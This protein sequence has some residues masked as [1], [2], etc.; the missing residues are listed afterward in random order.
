MVL[1]SRR[2]FRVVSE[3]WFLIRREKGF[4]RIGDIDGFYP[5]DGFTGLSPKFGFSLKTKRVIPRYGDTDGFYP[6]DGFTGLSP[7]FG[8]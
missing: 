5:V 3:V 4:P 1:P 8:F 7:K 2:I 6:V